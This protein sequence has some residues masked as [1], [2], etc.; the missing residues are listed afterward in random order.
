MSKKGFLDIVKQVRGDGDYA[1]DEFGG[2]SG[3]DGSGLPTGKPGNFMFATGTTVKS[4]ET[5]WK[6]VVITGVLK[7]ICI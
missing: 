2:G 5:F 4:G 1:G 7:K 3:R 6:S